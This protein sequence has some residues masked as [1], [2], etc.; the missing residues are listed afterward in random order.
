[1][2]QRNLRPHPIVSRAASPA[3]A[4]KDITTQ[5]GHSETHVVMIFSQPVLNLQ[6]TEEQAEATI[7]SLTEVL[8]H[9][10]VQKG[11]QA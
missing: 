2:K 1:M 5:Y 6:M 9:F 8:S 11:A 3:P 7:K 10:R 4:R